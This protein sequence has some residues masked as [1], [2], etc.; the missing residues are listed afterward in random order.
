MDTYE[1]LGETLR[2]LRA[3]LIQVIGHVDEVSAA[4][5][6][7]VAET[8]LRG[9]APTGPNPLVD[10]TSFTVHWDGRRCHL[11]NTLAFR[12]FQALAKRPDTYLST[13]DLME[14]IWSGQRSASAVRSAVC[15]LRRRLIRAGLAD[16]AARIDGGNRRHYALVLSGR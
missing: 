5:D 7:L 8:R 9:D 11:G 3:A 16:L 10:H 4:V 1:N 14:E 15:D 12:L 6:R 13:A 2:A